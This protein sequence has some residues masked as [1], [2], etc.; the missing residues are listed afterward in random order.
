[1][2]IGGCP[3]LAE[4]IGFA[5]IERGQHATVEPVGDNVLG[6]ERVE[7]VQ[8]LPHGSRRVHSRFIPGPEACFRYRARSRVPQRGGLE[9]RRLRHHAVTFELGIRT[10][11]HDQVE[12]V[13]AMFQ[14]AQRNVVAAQFA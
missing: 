4:G 11:V 3:Q 12:G 5:Q 14:F 6:H 13:G 2:R 9:L 8:F 7:L 10:L 1:M